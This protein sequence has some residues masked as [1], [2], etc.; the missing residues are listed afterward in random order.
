MRLAIM[1]PYF[2]PYLGHFSLIAAS[3]AWIVFDV[4]QYTPRT[5]MNR[6]R[7]LHPTGG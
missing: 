5:W 7:I 4:R 6:N 1:Q 3:D 2:F